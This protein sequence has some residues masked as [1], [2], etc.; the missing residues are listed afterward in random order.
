[1]SLCTALL[2]HTLTG[3]D[4]LEEWTYP[5]RAN[6]YYDEYRA[7]MAEHP[8]CADD[9][10]GGHEAYMAWRTLMYGARRDLVGRYTFAIPSPRVIT[11]LAKLGPIVEMGAGTGYWARLLEN[12]GVDVVAYD[13]VPVGEGLNEYHDAVNWFTVRAG[14]PA[15]LAAHCARALLLCWP[16]YDT[17]MASQCLD[18]YAGDTLIY[19]GEPRGGCTANRR[20]FNLLDREWDAVGSSSLPQWP[21]IDDVLT[22]YRR[23]SV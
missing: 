20:F 4:A 7:L 5:L 9:R 23:R 12:A 6:P 1:M 19:V 10:V 15:D 14:E 21:G 8:A 3:D 13:A 2:S 22:I 11:R 17:P 18:A 16:P